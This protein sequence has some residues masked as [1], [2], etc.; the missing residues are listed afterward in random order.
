M[1]KLI[2]TLLRPKLSHDDYLLIM[3]ALQRYSNELG[4]P[5]QNALVFAKQGAINNLAYRIN[6]L[7]GQ[8]S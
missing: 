8:V 2:Q 5:N 3:V 7:W 6:K 4:Q 1:T